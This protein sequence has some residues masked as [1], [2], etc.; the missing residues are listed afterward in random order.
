MPI[1][2]ERYEQTR[3]DSLRRSLQRESDK[4]KPRDYEIFVDGFKVVPRTSDLN[5][6]DDYEQEI[7]T[8]TRN[9]SF[10]LFDGPGTNR[11]TRYSF[12]FHNNQQSI[13]QPATLGEID[14]IVAQ[15]LSD[16][17]RDYE[18]NRLREKLQEAQ[19]QIEEAEEYSGTLQARIAELEQESKGKMMKWG[20]LGASILMG[21]LRNHA[22]KLPQG[23]SGLFD[24]DTTPKITDG[25][26]NES[27]EG[28]AS[29]SKTEDFDE[30]TR[31]RLALLEQMQQRLSEQQIIGVLNIIGYLTEHPAEIPTIIALLTENLKT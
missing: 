7:R 5:E 6:F 2:E 4:G 28:R 10:L 23:L 11:N 17:E 14:Q 25:G 1:V 20:D 13:E 9:V 12:S 15:K 22:H 30:H 21:V 19:E 27:Q 24:L 18:L 16:R 3:V 8:N 31:S 29:Y 26:L